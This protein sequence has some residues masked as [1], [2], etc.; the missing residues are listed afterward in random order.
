[1]SSCC[2]VSVFLDVHFYFLANHCSDSTC[3][4]DCVFMRSVG[5]LSLKIYMT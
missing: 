4:M 5:V 1:M 2:S 3:S